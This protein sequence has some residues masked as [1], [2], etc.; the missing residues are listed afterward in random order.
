MSD[1]HFFGKNFKLQVLAFFK[2]FFHKK[3]G[4]HLLNLDPGEKLLQ[5]CPFVY[6]KIVKYPF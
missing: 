2:P 4:R 1:N 3:K 5:I 6:K